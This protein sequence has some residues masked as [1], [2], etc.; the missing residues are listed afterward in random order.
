MSRSVHH[1]VFARVYARLADQMERHGVAEHRDELVRGLS[2]R[3]VEIGA[4][5]GLMFGHY[6]AEVT[7]VVAVEPEPTL[8]TRAAIAGARAQVPVSVHDAVADDL[9]FP[10]ASFDAAVASLVLCSVRDQASALAELR[11]VLRPGGE[12]RYYEHVLGER[13]AQQRL[14]RATDVVWP[15]FAGGCHTARDTPRAIRAAGFEVEE[16]RRFTFRP[17][18]LAAPVAPHVIGRAR[19]VRD[20]S[21]TP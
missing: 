14:Q 3:V 11:R 16:E 6:P 20:A 15:W 8:R 2:G 10:D 19:R 17:S 1:P 9:P 12:L 18:V 21:M 5:T 4:G 13:A 7:E